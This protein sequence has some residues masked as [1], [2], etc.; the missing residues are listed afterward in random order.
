ME[1][2]CNVWGD[3]PSCYLDMLHKLQK[4]VCR[5]VGPTLATSL[6]TLV[7][8]RNVV[9][10]MG[11][12]LIDVRLNLLNWFQFLILVGGLLVILTVCTIFLSPFLYVKGCRGS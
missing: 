3:T 9:F 10:S 1:Y 12:T 2:Y 6:E 11:I 7:H 5:I 8:R 4:R